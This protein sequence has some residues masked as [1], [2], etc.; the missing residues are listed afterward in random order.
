MH[1]SHPQKRRESSGV[2][3]QQTMQSRGIAMNVEGKQDGIAH[4]VLTKKMTPMGRIYGCVIQRL[5]E[6]DL[7]TIW[8]STVHYR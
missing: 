3:G 7:L 5:G 1:I 2:D 4:N 6:I 8:K